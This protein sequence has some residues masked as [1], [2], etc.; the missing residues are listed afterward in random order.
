MLDIHQMYIKK[1]EY[2]ASK[3]YIYYE[4]FIY[5]PKINK[6]LKR[7]L[8]FDNIKSYTYFEE[9][10]GNSS[11]NDDLLE[12]LDINVFTKIFYRNKKK[13]KIYM[14]D[15]KYSQLIVEFNDNKKWNYREQKKW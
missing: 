13:K 1:I 10:Y 3:L 15:G 14:F 2:I 7:I 6:D 5:N 9:E 4:Y 8:V 11:E 12:E